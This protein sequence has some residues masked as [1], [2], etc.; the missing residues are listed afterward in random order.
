MRNPFKY[1]KEVSGEQFYDREEDFKKLYR[2]LESGSANVVM[3]APRRYGKTSLVKNVLAKFNEAG[4]DTIYFDLNL[5]ENIE[6]FCEE[7]TTALYSL[8]GKTTQV[9]NTISRYLSHLHPVFSV[10]DKAKIS[11]KFDYGT[12]M[13]PSSI[14]D[15]L[16][17]VDKFAAERGKGPIVVAFDEFQE[18]GRLSP[19]LPLEGIFRSV[20]QSQQNVNYLF[21][22]SRT[23]V[24]QRM[25]GDHS[26]PFYRS[27]AVMKLDKPPEEES[28]RFIKARF[29]AYAVGIDDAVAERIVRESE[30]VPYYLQQL[31]YYTFESVLDG[32]RD[33]VEDSDI[34]AAIEVLLD[35]D[36]DYFLERVSNCSAA[37]R[38]VL[39]ALA[40]EP[41]KEFTED[42]RRRHSLGVSATVH[43]A[44]KVVVESGMVERDSKGYRIGDPFFARYL[45]K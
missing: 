8:A 23:H 10:G 44:L 27:A 36:S 18:I 37:Q 22:G 7:Y 28:M 39:S 40:Q 19:D 26:R 12:K 24:L 6:R 15:V 17:L 1:G 3:Y 2:A 42:Y 25:F 34:D 16:N 43:A 35:R 11:V 33:W 4:T 9:L 20:I 45:R 38:L 41:V 5:V 29:A 13:T 21:F 32:N 14:S 31:G 30:N